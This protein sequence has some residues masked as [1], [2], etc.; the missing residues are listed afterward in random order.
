MLLDMTPR[1]LL[2]MEDMD[3]IREMLVMKD[4]AQSLNVKNMLT[5]N[6][7]RSQSTNPRRFLVQCARPLLTQPT[8]RSVKT[9]SPSTVRRQPSRFTNILLLLAMTPK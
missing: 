6:V 5:D 9:L 2:I 3:T 8:S 1:L 7:T 4:T